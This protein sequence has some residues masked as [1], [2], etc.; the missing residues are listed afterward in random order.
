MSFAK[1]TLGVLGT[2][3]LMIFLSLA[4][5]IIVARMLGPGNRGMLEILSTVPHLVVSF[6]NLG[7]GN[8]N[9]YFIAKKKYSIE[10]IVANTVAISFLLGI[11]LLI[12]SFLIVGALSENVFRDIPVVYS[13]IAFAPIPF[14]LF[15]RYSE[16]IFLGKE[17]IGLRNRLNIIPGI[18]YFIFIILLVV[19]LKKGVSGVL[20]AQLISATIAFI[21]GVTLIKKLSRI[22]FQFDW[23]LFK[24][25]VGYGI[26]PFSALVILNLNFKA[27]I[28]FIKYFLDNTQVGYY[29]LGVSLGE[30]IWLVPE[31]IGL[32]LFS[33]VSNI[34][35]NE[36]NLLTPKL[37][38]I[39]LLFSVL[40]AIFLYC[41]G[42]WVIVLLYGVAFEPSVT[43][44]KLLLPG[45]VTMTLFL[46]V[47]SDLTGRGKAR[48]TL[49]VFS[50]ALVLN[51]LLNV[52]LIPRIGI[53]GAAIASS[54]S[55]SVGAIWLCFFFA[56]E[57]GLGIGDILF[58][59]RQDYHDH[60]APVIAKLMKRKS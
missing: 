23:Q 1:N 28:F 15:Q 5:G 47:H 42:Y 8:A 48:I 7:I 10:K 50:F 44:F 40:S 34:N 39:T 41:V 31:A 57:T 38:R 16:Y 21:L 36:A 52:I 19:L 29:S 59:K 13:V 55:Y 37:C 45:I 56:K 58:F 25:S 4:G 35:T 6:G 60:I 3:V 32:V 33:K 53:N 51:I 20:L 22:G 49:M 24:K 2:R 43:P 18:S 12:I 17:L 11:I 54:I 27:D 46:L 14:M 30:K 9:L 26:I